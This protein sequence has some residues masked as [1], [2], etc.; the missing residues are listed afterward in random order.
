MYFEGTGR[1]HAFIACSTEVPIYQGS[2]R[3]Q[4]KIE[5]PIEDEQVYEM[6]SLCKRSTL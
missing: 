4:I 1:M 2:V 3:L 5:K 6:V